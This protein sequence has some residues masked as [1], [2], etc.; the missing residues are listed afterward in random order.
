M[1]EIIFL[2]VDN[3]QNEIT[4]NFKIIISV[5]DEVK[6]F[7]LQECLDKPQEGARLIKKK[8][9]K[10]LRGPISRMKNRGEL[11]EGDILRVSLENFGGKPKLIFARKRN[12]ILPS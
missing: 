8:L 4:P 7:I 5:A 1:Q 2:E 12:K 10:F 9:L 3:F 11:K 6:D